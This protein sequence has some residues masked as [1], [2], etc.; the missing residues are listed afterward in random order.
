MPSAFLIFID[1]TH[2]H[3]EHLEHL[4]IRD[5]LLFAVVNTV[6]HFNIFFHHK[7]K[8]KKISN[9]EKVVYLLLGATLRS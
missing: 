9:I 1:V 5:Q 4:D 2:S 6:I 8:K 7:L 3:L